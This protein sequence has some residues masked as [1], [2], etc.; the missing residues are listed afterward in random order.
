M[1]DSNSH[2]AKEARKVIEARKASIRAKAQQQIEEADRDL[3][4][5]ERLEGVAAKYGLAVVPASVPGTAPAVQKA[6]GGPKSGRG[7]SLP[8]PDSATARAR[9]ESESIIRQL[10]R[11][12]PLSEL[13]EK[14]VARGVKFGGKNP[15]W[16]LSGILGR[17]ENF[18][19]TERGWWLKGVPMPPP[20][21]GGIRPGEF[22]LP[23][24]K[25]A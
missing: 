18:V 6:A 2:A 7:G 20:S 8:K 9:V 21:N 23:A 4:D 19:S 25:H 22:E 16:A 14:I 1:S 13:Y 24:R 12:V 3:A 5:I 10:G 17:M 11:P 15:S